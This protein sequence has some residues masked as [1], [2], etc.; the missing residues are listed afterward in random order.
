LMASPTLLKSHHAAT[1][2]HRCMRTYM[3]GDPS[4][5]PLDCESCCLAEIA[6]K[7]NERKQSGAR[8]VAL[9]HLT[10]AVYGARR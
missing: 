4:E 2:A 10:A 6:R 5:T 9:H 3:M 1:A 8:L 7:Q